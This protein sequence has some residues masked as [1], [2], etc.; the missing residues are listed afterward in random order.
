MSEGCAL[1]TPGHPRVGSTM[2]RN[3]QQHPLSPSSILCLLQLVSAQCCG[4]IHQLLQTCFTSHSQN[5]QMPWNVSLEVARA[6]WRNLKCLPSQECGSQAPSPL[7]C[8]WQRWR[9]GCCFRWVPGWPQGGETALGSCSPWWPHG[10]REKLSFVV[11][12]PEAWGC[13]LLLPCKPACLT[14]AP[15]ETVAE[16][17]ASPPQ[18]REQWG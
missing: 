18:A 11:E 7:A 1:W 8:A 17:G 16:E 2:R 3:G 12:T 15:P 5:G 14:T 13:C 4:F 9:R 10:V 6:A